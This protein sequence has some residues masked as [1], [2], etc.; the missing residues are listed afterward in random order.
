MLDCEN[1]QKRCEYFKK[2]TKNEWKFWGKAIQIQCGLSLTSRLHTLDYKCK[3]FETFIED[4]CSG[5][6][7]QKKNSSF[8]VEN[9]PSLGHA[10]FEVNIDATFWDQIKE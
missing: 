6:L 9:P 1:T 10:S 3:F 4:D 8:F 2:S 5:G 7:Q